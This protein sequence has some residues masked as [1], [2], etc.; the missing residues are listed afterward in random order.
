M[1][2]LDKDNIYEDLDRSGKDSSDR[3]EGRQGSTTG[4]NRRSQ[5][6]DQW[7][8]HKQAQSTS[9]G[10][11]K[12]GDFN[13]CNRSEKTSV[14]TLATGHDV[15]SPAPGFRGTNDIT[16]ENKMLVKDNKDDNFN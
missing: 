9:N 3:I 7:E 12:T 4:P 6:L 8:Q 11:Q 15:L 5:L 14:T 1:D 16:E 2:N 13:T 10:Q